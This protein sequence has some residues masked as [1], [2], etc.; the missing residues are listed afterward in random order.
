MLDA[1]KGYVVLGAALVSVL[2][3]FALL[4]LIVVLLGVKATVT[5]VVTYAACV[6]VLRSAVNDR[7]PAVTEKDLARETEKLTDLQNRPG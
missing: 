2:L 5:I 4:G 7:A 1:L 6:L 3:A